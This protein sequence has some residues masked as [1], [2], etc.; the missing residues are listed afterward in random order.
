M[1]REVHCLL[2]LARPFAV[3][4][5]IN[6]SGFV[7]ITSLW[8]SVTQQATASAPSTYMVGKTENLAAVLENP[9]LLKKRAASYFK[10]ADAD[11]NGSISHEEA[12]AIIR[13]ISDKGHFPMPSEDKVMALIRR[14]DKSK[15]GALQP[16]EWQLFFK[17]IVGSALQRRKRQ[18]A[19][20]GVAADAPPSPSAAAPVAIPA[21]EAAAEAPAPAAEITTTPSTTGAGTTV[22][23][24]SK[25]SAFGTFLENMAARTQSATQSVGGSVGCFACA[26]PRHAVKAA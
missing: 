12:L 2:P 9:E 7:I 5:K 22:A 24:V 19:E 18:E 4:M 6:L 26:T 14:C 25:K 8:D 10:E 21:V 23:P 11:G 20:G 3:N 16:D 17:V 13:S 15:D 1:A